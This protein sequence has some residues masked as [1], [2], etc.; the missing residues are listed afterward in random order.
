MEQVQAIIDVIN[1]AIDEGRGLT[2]KADEVIITAA[3]GG[4]P[5]TTIN[6]LEITI[7]A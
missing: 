7:D 5:T 4:V 2:I 1:K 3:M 6:G